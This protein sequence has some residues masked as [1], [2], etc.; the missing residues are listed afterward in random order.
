MA[1]LL[2]MRTR[3]KSALAIQGTEFDTDIDDSIRSSLLELQQ[4]RM[5]FLEKK[6][7]VTLLDGADS[8]ALPD[9][10]GSGKNARILINTVYRGETQGF[11]KH[12]FR[13]L[14]EVYRRTLYDG[15]PQNYAY[16]GTTL[17]V[18][19]TANADYPIDLTYYQKDV[20]LPTDDTDTSIWFDDGYDA[21]RTL[22]M[23][24]FKDEVEGYDT[25]PADWS[26]A[27]NYASKLRG[28]NTYFQLGAQ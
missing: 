14:E 19:V 15:Y 11:I 20:T 6:G 9:D 4:G 8:V 24:M 28:R 27:E 18:D 22:A 25:A 16:Y 21:V 26:R 3:I 17:Y 7:T 5:W 1:T 23:A 10:F 12:D 13:T 2:D